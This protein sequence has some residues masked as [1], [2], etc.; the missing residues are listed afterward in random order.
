MPDLTIWWMPEAVWPGILYPFI[1]L[2]PAGRLWRIANH[3]NAWQAKHVIKWTK[4][5]AEEPLPERIALIVGGMLGLT[6]CTPPT[7]LEAAEVGEFLAAERQ[8]FE[9][10]DRR[11][12][13]VKRQPESFVEVRA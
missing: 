12:G 13:T 7:P 3:Q 4:L 8:D 11:S 9:R 1:A 2:S 10:G 6:G 5:P